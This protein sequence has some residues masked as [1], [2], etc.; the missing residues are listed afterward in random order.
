MAKRWCMSHSTAANQS[1]SSSWPSFT[2]KINRSFIFRKII[3]QVRSCPHFFHQLNFNNASRTQFSTANAMRR[4][5]NHVQIRL[6]NCAT[7]TIVWS[8]RTLNSWFSCSQKITFTDPLPIV[9]PFFKQIGL[10]GLAT[11][12][13]V[14]G[15]TG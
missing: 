6:A 2:L 10:A 1:P 13:F 4:Q 5:S 11:A 14:G 8:S 9:K 3:I 12:N 7:I 15:H